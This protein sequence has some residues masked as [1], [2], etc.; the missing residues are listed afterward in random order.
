MISRDHA[1]RFVTFAAIT[2]RQSIVPLS[3][4]PRLTTPQVSNPASA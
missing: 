2:R 4:A 3:D 1:Q